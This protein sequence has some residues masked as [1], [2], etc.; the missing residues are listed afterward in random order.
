[1]ELV[2]RS[3][4]GMGRDREWIEPFIFLVCW[5]PS[6]SVCYVLFLFSSEDL[7]YRLNPLPFIQLSGPIA[8]KFF[9]CHNIVSD[10]LF[11]VLYCVDM[12]ILKCM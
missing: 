9:R 10:Y 5:H 6:Q 12:Y 7:S 2:L 3:L 11:F 1:M 8:Q 4:R